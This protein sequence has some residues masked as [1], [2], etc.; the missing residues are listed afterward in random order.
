MFEAGST[1]ATGRPA[2]PYEQIDVPCRWGPA[3]FAWV[4]RA[5]ELG[6][7]S[8]ALY[9]HGNAS[10]VASQVNIAHY[11]V[12]HNAGLNVLAPEYRGFG[13]VSGAPTEAALQA[14]ARAA[15]DY[16]RKTRGCRRTQ[17]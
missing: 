16:L 17:S 14:D 10:S 9:L 6:C 7:R 11:R 4:M 1:L 2:F 3:Q 8:W 5:A 13:G 12:L 15:Y